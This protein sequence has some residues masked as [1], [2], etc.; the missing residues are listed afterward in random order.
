MKIFQEIQG[1]SGFFVVLVCFETVC[2]GCFASIPKQRVS[3][4]RFNRNKQK[5]NRNS[6]IESIFWY[7]KENLGLYRFA[8]KQ[9]CLFRLF[10][11]RF[12]TPKQTEIFLLQPAADISSKM[13]CTVSAQTIKMSTEKETAVIHTHLDRVL[14]IIKQKNLRNGEQ[15]SLLILIQLLYQLAAGAPIKHFKR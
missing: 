6:L 8:S 1:F 12:E 3:M 13:F 10:R 5:T 14:Q 9:F 2:L 4:F 7:F 15:M 11:Y